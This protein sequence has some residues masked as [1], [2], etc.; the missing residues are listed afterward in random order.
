MRD[1]VHDRKKNLDFVICTASGGVQIPSQITLRSMVDSYDIDLTPTEIAE[2]NALP[3]CAVPR[4]EA[5]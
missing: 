2:L 4:S 1:F 3:S 5:F